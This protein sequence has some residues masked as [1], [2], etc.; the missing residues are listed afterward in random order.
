MPMDTAIDEIEYIKNILSR[1]PE[2][3][4]HEVR[5]FAAYLADRERRRKALVDRVLKAENQ[6]D[7]VIC[8]TPEEAMQAILNYQDD[9]EE[10]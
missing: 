5:D 2:S 4:V 7:S 1:L 10:A 8:L 9:D 3:V 6:H